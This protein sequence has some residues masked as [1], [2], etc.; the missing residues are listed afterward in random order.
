MW[1]SNGDPDFARHALE[2]YQDALDTALVNRATDQVFYLAINLAFLEFVAFDH[3][4]RATE[5]AQLA[6]TYAR[7]A[8]PSVWSMATEAEANLYLDTSTKRLTDTNRW[9]P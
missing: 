1:F 7:A 9:W 5:M 3:T 2:L 4:D 8:A 6:L